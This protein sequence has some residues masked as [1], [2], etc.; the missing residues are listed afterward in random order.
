MWSGLLEEDVGGVDVDL[1]MSNTEPGTFRAA[2][3][4]SF[5]IMHSPSCCFQT[6]V[7]F[8][9]WKNVCGNI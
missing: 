6:A 2:L 7:I 8:G 1:V 9:L 4:E 3:K 5:V